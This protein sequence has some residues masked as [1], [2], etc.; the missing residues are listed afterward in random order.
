MNRRDFLALSAASFATLGA[1]PAWAA[2]A[3]GG[4]S[5]LVVVMLRG[6]V[7]GLNVVVPYG[8]AAY[9]DHAPHDRD[10]RSRAA[11]KAASRSTGISR[12]TRRS[13]R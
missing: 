6:A 10:R 1:T 11:M 4:P 13:P 7:D 5:R 8:D 3:E 12:S 9:Y 2:S